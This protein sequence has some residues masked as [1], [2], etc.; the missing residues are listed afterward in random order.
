MNRGA[1]TIPEGPSPSRRRSLGGPLGILLGA[2][3]ITML[4]L[5]GGTAGDGR[6]EPRL[7]EG[8]VTV[9][10]VPEVWVD[11]LNDGDIAAALRLLDPSWEILELP[12]L[13]AGYFRD[14][15]RTRV[16]EGLALF[17]ELMALDLGSCEE[18]L[19]ERGNVVR[20]ADAR[21][22]SPYADAVQV[23]LGPIPMTFILREGKLA[24]VLRG[25]EGAPQ[26]RDYCHWAEEFRTSGLSPFDLGCRPVLVE[27]AG[28]LHFALSDG[29]IDAGF[30]YAPFRFRVER[31]RAQLVSA[32]GNA[33]NRG[34]GTEAF[35]APGLTVDSF[36]GPFPTGGA[37]IAAISSWSAVVADFD[38]G[39]CRLRTDGAG[40]VTGVTCPEVTLTGPLVERLGVEPERQLVDFTLNGRSI[41]SISAAPLDDL[42]SAYRVFCAWLRDTR[43]ETAAEVLADDCAPVY[44]PRAASLLLDAAADYA[45]ALTP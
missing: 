13:P 27:D 31:A 8:I 9:S 19:D 28:A 1:V 43:E 39:S 17:S 15:E 20:C 41:T 14:L 10:A 2:L 26:L 7:D 35:T 18:S 3:L 22:S 32:F 16:G 45:A 4:F 33:F 38:I 42:A 6:T 5:V 24:V 37:S 23:S 36:P 12:G 40:S 44:D 25:V 21:V 29:F 11:S 34:A 30:P